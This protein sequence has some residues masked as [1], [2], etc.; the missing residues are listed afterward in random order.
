MLTTSSGTPFDVT[1]V[2]EEDIVKICIKQGHTR[3][4]GLLHY[5]A[6]ELVILFQLADEMQ[7]ATHGAIK[8][9]VQCEEAIAIRASAPSEAHIRAY[10]SA[11]DGK[12]FGTQA[13]PLEGD[14][15][16]LSPTE[17]PHPGGET[18]HCLQTDLGDLADQELHQLLE[19]L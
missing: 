12:P 2:L 10:M 7:C 17:N 11:V 5:S 16:P 6:M 14:G 9:L 3:A 18:P 13:S 1:S 4:M 19:D 15:G 8:A